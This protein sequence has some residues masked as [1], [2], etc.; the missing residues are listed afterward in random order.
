MALEIEA[1]HTA[2]EC[3]EEE[4]I[5]RRKYGP[6]DET[7]ADALH[8]FGSVL[9]D[10]DD[11]ERAMD[12][13]VEELDVRA[14]VLGPDDLSVAEVLDTIGA[15]HLESGDHVEALQSFSRLAKIQKLRLG[16]DHEDVAETL[17]SIGLILLSLNDH[18]EAVVAFR[19]VVEIRQ[20]TFGPMDEAVG[21]ALNITGFL[22]M[23]NGNKEQALKLLAKALDIRRH[24]EEWAKAADTLQQIGDIHRESQDFDLAIDCY[25]EC[26]KLSSKELGTED[27]GIADGYIA[28]G[29]IQSAVGK[30]A[31]AGSS[32]QGAYFII[33]RE[34]GD[35]DE[36]VMPL[37]LKMG[38]ARLRAGD[39]DQAEQNLDQFVRLRKT[40]GENSD[41]DYVN[42]LRII[43]SIRMAEGDEKGAM[44]VW[45]E[46]FDA[47]TNNRLAYDHPRVGEKLRNLLDG[48]EDNEEEGPGIAALFN[49]LRR[50]GGV[51]ESTNISQSAEDVVNQATF[52][53]TK[54]LDDRSFQTSSRSL[55]SSMK[56]S[57]S[58]RGDGYSVTSRSITSRSRTSRGR[59]SR[60]SSRI[61]FDER[62]VGGS[63]EQGIGQRAYNKYR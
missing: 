59:R 12:A 57:H 43:G 15:L 50:K 21:D 5:L 32:Y 1:L 4:C 30:H 14:K 44:E 33:M 49:T 22:E 31:D 23:K 16:P 47:Y 10:L 28:L 26:L 40:R 6:Q 36:R 25:K 2:L 11:N 39:N 53:S 60:R 35:D 54:D 18:D 13:F 17:Y 19:E 8:A 3:F 63:I 9:L 51:M 61:F 7:F 24:N 45:E 58:L 38:M 20:Q 46:A 56:D 52:F 34:L 62:S 41:I 37:L 55:M 42:A 27:E 48:F 29:N